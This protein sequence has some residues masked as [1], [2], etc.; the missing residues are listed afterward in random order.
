MSMSKN[1]RIILAHNIK[2]DRS[3]KNVINYTEVQMVSLCEANVTAQATDFTFIRDDNSILVPFNYATCLDSNYLAFQNPSYSNKW[4]F[5]WI[6]K[7]KYKNDGTTQIDYTIDIFSTWFSYVTTKPCI[8]IREHVN[9]D[10]VGANTVPEGLETG[11]YIC[12]QHVIDDAMDELTSELMYVLSTTLDLS[13]SPSSVT[14]FSQAGVRK[15]NGIASGCVYYPLFTTSELSI[16][17]NAVA[18]KGQIDGINGLFMAPKIFLGSATGPEM[19]QGDAPVTYNNSISKMTT[20]QGYSPKNKKLLCYPY[21][22]LLASNNNGSSYIYNYEDFS[23][24]SCNFK[25]DMAITPGC[26]IRMIPKNYKGIAE[27]DEYGINM[28]KLP[29]CSYP[30][31]MYTNWLTQNSINIAG[32]TVSTDDINIGMAGT[33]ALLGTIGNIASG[34]VSGAIGSAVNGAGSIANA[35]IT[36]KQHELIPAQARG[37]LN[38]GDVVTSEG[39]NT[40]HFY[41]MSI[42]Q[43]FAKIIDD[44]FTRYGY[45]V[46]RLKTPN[47]TGR[48]YFNYVQIGTDEVVG[49]GSMENSYMEVINQIF[50]SVTTIWHNHDNMYNYNLDNNI[51]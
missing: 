6:D 37:N 34:N 9:N 10:T 29:I 40:F 32:H 33:N 35:L 3:Y 28:G 14:K 27:N 13:P 2:M 46:N 7:V 24:G 31:D 15:Y 16:V 44:Y 1:S 22:Y 25:I 20:L 23:D 39:K 12:N 48:S 50:R 51:I 36:Q 42:K 17:L 8:V 18:D 19:P 30:V 49:I 21:N 26:S 43:E 4:F 38:A 5:A 41:K 11:E 45:K 47:I